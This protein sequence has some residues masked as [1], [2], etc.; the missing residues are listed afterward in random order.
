MSTVLAQ[1]PC[2]IY[3]TK[4]HIADLRKIIQV[5]DEKGGN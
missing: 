4:T 2:A 3:F 5:D 1:Q